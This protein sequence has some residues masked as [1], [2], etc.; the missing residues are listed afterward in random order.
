MSNFRAGEEWDLT[1]DCKVK[2]SLGWYDA[3]DYERQ[4]QAVD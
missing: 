4:M 2:S 1:D 3:D